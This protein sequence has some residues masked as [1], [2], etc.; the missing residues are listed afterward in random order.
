MHGNEKFIITVKSNHCF[1]KRKKEKTEFSFFS[2]FSLNL[3]FF[4]GINC[5]FKSLNIFENNRDCF[6]KKINE[7]KKA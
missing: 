3:T 2:V 6:W 1:K 5:L 7:K 4:Q